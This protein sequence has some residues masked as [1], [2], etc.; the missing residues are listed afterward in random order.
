MVEL[1]DK[2]TIDPETTEEKFIA[3]GRKEKALR[4]ARISLTDRFGGLE[5]SLSLALEALDIDTL[6]EIYEN[7]TL[8]MDELYTR[9]GLPRRSQRRTPGRGWGGIR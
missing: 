7:S 1:T 5:H 8:S 2:R 4:M 9:V 3:K 6:A